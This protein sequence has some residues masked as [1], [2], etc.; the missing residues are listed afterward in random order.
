LVIPAD[1]LSVERQVESTPRI[2]EVTTTEVSTT[3]VQCQCLCPRCDAQLKIKYDEPECLQCGY[4]D[5]DY[6]PPNAYKRRKGLLSAATRYVLR[7][8][9]DFPSLSETL[10]HVQLKRVGTRAV[11]SV[12]C[13]FCGLP[14]IQSPLSGKRKEIR[15]ERFKCEAG[16]RVSLTPNKNGSFGW[17]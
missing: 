2:Y 17:K 16:H 4:V 14:M 1:S 15:E 6:T 11:F 3:R 7:Y 10:A 8:V 12:T 5:Y 9:G 13:P